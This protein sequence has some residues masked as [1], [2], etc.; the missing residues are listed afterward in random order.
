[1]A[2][3]RLA[4]RLGGA[5]SSLQP[6]DEEGVEDSCQRM[7][8]ER[9]QRVPEAIRRCYG[10]LAQSWSSMDAMSGA[11]M[12]LLRR[13]VLLWQQTGHPAPI[14]VAWTVR[15]LRA[16][17]GCLHAME[18][19]ALV[20]APLAAEILRWV[21]QLEAQERARNPEAGD[22]N[23]TEDTLE[24]HDA[25]L[26]RRPRSAAALYPRAYPFQPSVAWFESFGSHCTRY[27]TRPGGDRRSRL[28]SLRN[29]LCHG[30]FAGWSAIQKVLDVASESV[31]SR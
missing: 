15:G 25:F 28:L 26:A 16:P 12:H 1:V 8:S 17:G 5:W 9:V 2:T 29:A 20:N 30:H 19:A 6:F 24:Q 14:P 4:E 23:Y 21:F 7:A 18:R 22:G 27:L 3:S 31:F 13:E 10:A 11:D